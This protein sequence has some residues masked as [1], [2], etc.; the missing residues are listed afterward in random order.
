MTK[1]EWSREWKEFKK[2]VEATWPKKENI[3]YLVWLRDGVG[4]EN[5][6]LRIAKFNRAENINRR[7]GEWTNDGVFIDPSHWCELPPRPYF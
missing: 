1:S 2:D 3:N 4:V 6:H 7:W 5:P